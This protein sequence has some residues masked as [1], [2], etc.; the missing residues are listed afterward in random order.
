MSWGLNL[1]ARSAFPLGKIYDTQCGFKAYPY[2]YAKMIAEMQ[3]MERFS[4]DL[5]HILIVKLN[6][7]EVK[8]IPIHYYKQETSTVRPVHDT[9][10]FFRDLVIIRGNYKKGLYE[11][12][13]ERTTIPWKN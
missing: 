3:H 2:V 1:M 6:G 5:E 11:K 9:I 13:Y 8:D 7:G 12:H 10:L 4:F